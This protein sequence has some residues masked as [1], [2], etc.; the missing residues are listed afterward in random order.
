M[1]IV[2]AVAR[3]IPGVLGHKESLEEHR[4]G[5]G[6]PQYTRPPVFKG[7]KVPKELLTGHHKKIEE[8]R[9]KYQ[10]K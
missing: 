2:D 1:V 7:W 3:H 10:K 4:G 8:W 6:I 9:K 5:V